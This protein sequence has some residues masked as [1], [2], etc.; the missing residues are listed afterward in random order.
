M[1]ARIKTY[2]DMDGVLADFFRGACDLHGYSFGEYP[3][4]EWSMEKVL[5]LSWDAFARDMDAEW[6]ANLPKCPDADYIVSHAVNPIFLTSHMDGRS[7]DGKHLWAERYYP[8]I[9]IVFTHDKGLVACNSSVLIDDRKK[10]V[11]DF[12]LGGGLAAV[13][14]P[15]EWRGCTLT[16][17]EVFDSEYLERFSCQVA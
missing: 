2:L 9:G 8:G 6:W 1:V 5:G 16:P 10:N 4:G 13:H 15:S 17:R 14:I 12:L 3:R 7:V 11:D